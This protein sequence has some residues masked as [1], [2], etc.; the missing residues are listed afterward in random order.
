VTNVLA[1]RLNLGNVEEAIQ[2]F[3]YVLR[4]Q[5]DAANIHNDLGIA[6]A[7]AATK[8]AEKQHESDSP[9]DRPASLSLGL[10]HP[11]HFNGCRGAG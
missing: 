8:I 7:P 5:P 11:W 9:A 1:C 10:G 4:L 6:H 2:L 3:Q